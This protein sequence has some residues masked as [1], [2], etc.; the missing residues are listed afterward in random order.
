MT[1]VKF[2]QMAAQGVPGWV[3]GSIGSGRE[4]P[5]LPSTA[6]PP[7]PCPELTTPQAVGRGRETPGAQLGALR[8]A[9]TELTLEPGEPRG[10]RW[11]QQH[12]K[13]GEWYGLGSASVAGGQRRLS[14][15]RL[16]PYPFPD[17]RV[18]LLSHSPSGRSARPSLGNTPA[19]GPTLPPLLQAHRTGAAFLQGP[20]RRR[21]AL[22]AAGEGDSHSTPAGEPVSLGPACALLFGLPLLGGMG[23]A[24]PRW[25]SQPLVR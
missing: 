24:T 19:A 14:G 1:C 9:A 15:L 2:W 4:L 18:L 25:C 17:V 7:E 5:R 6:Q 16:Q 21:V 8:V 23:Q 13:Q 12:P 20:L 3:V 22:G 10:G 11:A